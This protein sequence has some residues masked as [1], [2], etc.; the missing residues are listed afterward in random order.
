MRRRE[1]ITI[2][3]GAAFAWPLRGWAQQAPRTYRIGYLAHAK[4]PHLIDALHK[5]LRELG[6]I[7]GQNLNVDY[8]FGSPEAL[9]ALA[10]ELVRLKLDAIVTVATPAV[11]PAKRATTVI[12][13]VI[14]SE[15]ANAATSRGRCRTRCCLRT[16]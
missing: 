10:A 8:R 12:P 1:L 13:I 9:D 4:L 5:G 15:R 16:L 6:Y 11:L 2:L 3:G 14:V 7:E